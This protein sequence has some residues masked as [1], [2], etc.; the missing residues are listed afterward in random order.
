M[1]TI[2]YRPLK[3]LSEFKAAEALQRAVWGEGDKEDPF[4]LLMVVQQ[5]GGLVGGAFKDSHLLGFVFGFPTRHQDVQYS[6]RLAVL[7][8]ARGL[9]LGLGL[10]RFQRRWCL[11][12]GIRCIRWT[13]D[14]LR[15]AN[16]ALNI[17]ALGAQASTYYCDFY[18]E[19]EGINKGAPSDRLQVEWFLDA[20]VAIRRMEGDRSPLEF[21]SATTRAIVI[22]V[23]FENL[24]SSDPEGATKIRLETRA[25]FQQA[26]ADGYVIKDFDPARHS[27]ILSSS[28]RVSLRSEIG[29]KA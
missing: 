28:E 13:Y 26:L 3:G 16:A 20:P 25:I 22:P 17:R 4:D 7:P 29:N 27:Y 14:P 15:A 23:G 8:A 10:K 24:L 18:G 21:A 1:T 12:N 19:L 6:H 9:G 2:E 11:E 5:Q